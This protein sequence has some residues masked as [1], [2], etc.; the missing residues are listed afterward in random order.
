[1]N[2]EALDKAAD[3]S[4][5]TLEEK[6]TDKYA[7]AAVMTP[8]GRG[9]FKAMFKDGVRYAIRTLWHTS[10]D[11]PRKEAMLLVVKPHRGEACFVDIQ[12]WLV[13]TDGTLYND[14]HGKAAYE[15]VVGAETKWLYLDDILL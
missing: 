11:I 2:R 13:L 9:M 3:D 14:R 5:R 7:G 12:L 10:G 1:M 6:I 4:L 8:F 15:E